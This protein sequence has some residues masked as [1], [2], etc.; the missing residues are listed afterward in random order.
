MS[1]SYDIRPLQLRLLAI[2]EAFDRMCRRHGLR[3]YLEF[4]TLLGAM[5]HGGFIPWD[6]DLDIMMPRPDYEKLIRH[7]R[8]GLPEPFEFVCF[9]N[10]PA[11]PLQFGKVQDAS[12]TLVERP[13]L[14]YLGGV[15]IDVFPV[16]GLP[17]SP[18]EQQKLYGRYHRLK[19]LLYIVW[20]DPY[21]HGHGPSS[22]W[23]LLMRRIFRPAKVQKMIRDLSLTYPFEKSKYVACLFGQKLRPLDR[24]AQLGDGTPITFEGKEFMTVVN[25]DEHLTQIYGDY[26]TPP[27]PQEIQ[28]HGFYYLDLDHPYRDFDPSL[29]PKSNLP[30]SK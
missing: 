1:T 18:K 12:T 23:P 3:Y 30:K 28:Q 16:D 24:V 8:E 19:S 6:D 11:Y 22:W 17:D 26:M 20:R 25:P 10:D 7:S 15:F 9:E 2:L 4:G 5:R 14:Y 21:K 27:P 13:H 29:L